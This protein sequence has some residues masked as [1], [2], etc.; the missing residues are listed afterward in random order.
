MNYPLNN[1]TTS[2]YYCPKPMNTPRPGA[3][4][5]LAIPSLTT[6]MVPPKPVTV[7]LPPPTTIAPKTRPAVDVA[8]PAETDAVG[9]LP[10]PGSVAWRLCVLYR[11]KPGVSYTAVDV[12]RNFAT[13]K[14]LVDNLLARSVA[15]GLL[16][17]QR[18]CAEVFYSAGPHIAR[19]EAAYLPTEPKEPKVAITKQI[20]AKPVKPT[21]RAPEDHSTPYKPQTVLIEELQPEPGP[22][23]PECLQPMQT[24]TIRPTRAKTSYANPA[25]LV[26]CDDPLPSARALPDLKYEAVFA[27]L[28]PGKCIKCAPADVGKIAGGLRKHFERRG[29]T[30]KVKTTSSY[31]ADGMGRV[32]WVADKKAA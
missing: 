3:D 13:K 6:G 4:A 28:V 27:K 11:E 30:D 1:G 31:E 22:P 12:A 8:T 7:I 32:W 18:D 9:Y 17:R 20:P 19:I 24:S 2:S 5:H 29:I 26:I 15:A 25:A 10:K 23:K 21:K 14:D 16:L